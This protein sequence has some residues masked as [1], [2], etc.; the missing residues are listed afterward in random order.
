VMAQLV[1]LDEAAHSDAASGPGADDVLALE[2][3]LTE[4]ETLDPRQAQLVEARFFGGLDVRELM[5]LFAVS[6]AT[7]MRDWRTARAW[8]AQRMR[9]NPA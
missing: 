5:D 9:G 1:P 3:A 6:E 2:T 7:I 4:L 8:L